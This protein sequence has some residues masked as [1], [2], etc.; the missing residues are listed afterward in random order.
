M[1]FNVP[2]YILLTGGQA[3]GLVYTLYDSTNTVLLQIKEKAGTPED[4][5]KMNFRQALTLLFPIAFLFP[6]TSAWFIVSP[7]NILIS[8]PH[9][10]FLLYGFIFAS[11]L[12]RMMVDRITKI[13]TSPF[14][15]QLLIPFVGLL[16]ALFSD[17][18]LFILFGGLAILLVSYFHFVLGIISQFC[19][20]LKINCFR[21]PY[22]PIQKK[23]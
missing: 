11:M 15:W 17:K 8:Y 14:H 4:W 1:G 23:T 18:D 6:V 21:I 19:K 22:P 5:Q 9:Q 3:I 20:A 12:N 2:L 16:T 13:P 10:C 7:N